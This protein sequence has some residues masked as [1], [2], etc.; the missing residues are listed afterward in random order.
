MSFKKSK[1]LKKCVGI[2]KV[3][4]NILNTAADLRDIEKE[5]IGFVNYDVL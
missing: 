1:I 2:R 4:L 3:L 5:S